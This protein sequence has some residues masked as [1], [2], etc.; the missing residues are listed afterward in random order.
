MGRYKELQEMPH[1][2][3]GSGLCFMDARRVTMRH[4]GKVQYKGLPTGSSNPLH[5]GKKWLTWG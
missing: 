5:H 2:I 4:S 3:M 1:N